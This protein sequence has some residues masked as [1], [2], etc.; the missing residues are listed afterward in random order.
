[1]M[2]STTAVLQATASAGTSFCT[3]LAHLCCEVHDGVDLLCLQDK[4]QQV[5]GLDVALDQLQQQPP[6]SNTR[7]LKSVGSQGSRSGAQDGLAVKC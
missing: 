7:T 1:M 2:E 6:N 4:A 5:H 3:V